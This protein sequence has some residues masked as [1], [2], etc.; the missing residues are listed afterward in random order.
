MRKII[1]L[2]LRSYLNLLKSLATFIYSVIFIIV[3]KYNIT[4]MLFDAMEDINIV[5]WTS[6]I[7]GFALQAL[8]LFQHMVY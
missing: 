1:E 5:S 4:L 2:M 3:S 7:M 6:T 8:E